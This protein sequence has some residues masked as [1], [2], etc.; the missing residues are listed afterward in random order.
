MKSSKRRLQALAEGSEGLSNYLKMED[1]ETSIPPVFRSRLHELFSQIEKEFDLL[2][3]ENLNLQ[4]KIDILSEKLERE[5]CVG[6]KQNADYIEFETT[7]KSS[8]AKISQNN[9]Q[10][11]KTSHKLR[12][13]TSKI[14]SSFKAPTYNCQLVREFTGHKDG[15]WDVSS[16][17]PG[18]ALIGTASAD[19]TACIWSVEWG[20]C[21]LQYTGHAGSVNSLK[22][23]PTRD[24]ALTSS[25]DNTAHVWQAAVNWDLPRGQSSEEELEGGGEES[26]GETDRPE[27]L[28]TPLSELMGHQGVVVAADWLTGGEH[29]I[30]ASW[31]R[32]ANLYDVETGDCLQILT[33]HD[34]ELTHASA[35]HS[36]RLVVTASRDTTFRLWDFREPIHSVSVFQGHTESVTS[37]VFTR[38]DKVVSGSDDRSVKVWDV[39]N[40]RSALATIRSDS[41]VNRVSVSSGGLIA[42]P[43]DN[44]QVRLFDLQGQ[45]LARL[46]R[47]SRQG[48][49]RMV[50]SVAW[51]ED[52]SSG[53]NFFSCG[54]DRRI[55]G[56]SIQPS[57]EN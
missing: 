30:T 5:S 41:S 4:E 15:I 32:T 52:M 10:K 49:R 1:S 19:H 2:Y 33:G 9:S 38:E 11:V 23:H 22:F 44:R 40:M 14:V 25:G 54:F 43:H 20:K 51:S 55:L 7:G 3:S 18:Q 16:A 27:V 29:V 31:D 13:Q 8:K 17:R 35:H 36:S 34:H 28:R 48:H 57:K 42:I 24:I 56:W 50:T 37:A 45:R 47:S 39:R 6:D 46:P 12:V 53:I 21:L 26:M